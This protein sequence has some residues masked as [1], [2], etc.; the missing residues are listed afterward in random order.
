MGED[1]AASAERLVD[2]LRHAVEALG[3]EEELPRRPF[4]AAAALGPARD[5]AARGVPRA[6]GGRSPF[7]DAVGRLA[8]ESLAAYPP[9]IPNVLPGE[10]LTR[11]R[12]TTSARWSSTAA[13]CGAPSTAACG[14]SGW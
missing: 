3:A 10:R 5:A 13:G 14:R 6:A 2:A 1:A 7:D 11:R 12:S 4:A 9:G 8:A